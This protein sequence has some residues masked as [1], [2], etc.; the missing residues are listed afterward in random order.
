MNPLVEYPNPRQYS[1]EFI[2][3]FL[4]DIFIISSIIIIILLFTIY[5]T[6]KNKKNENNKTEPKEIS[7]SQTSSTLNKSTTWL[8]DYKIEKL[9]GQGA[10]S[11]V[12]LVTKGGKQYA[13]KVFQHEDPEL[14]ERFKREIEILKQIKHI[15][16]VSI[17]DFGED[18]NKPY[19]I[20]EYVD[21]KTLD[22]IYLDL[23]FLQRLDI[24][25]AVSNALNYLHSKGIIHRDIKPENILVD[26]E[27]KNIK[28]TDLGISRI[29]YWRPLTQDGQILGT[30][31]YMAPEL[32]E[33]VYTDPRIDIYSLGITMYEIFTGKLPFEGSP[34]EIVIKHL[35]E[36]PV[37][38][39]LINP[40]IPTQLEKIIMKAIEKNPEKRYKNI[41]KLI[42]DLILV[43]EILKKS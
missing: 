9:L 8:G 13:A 36:T 14:L 35:K 30:P 27:L 4:S 33:G 16:L 17:V 39:S 6:K 31:A 41:S 7:E 26:K 10:T 23:T 18:N 25:I 1:L 29:V 21:G 3:G 22:E 28:L 38:P 42:E 32:F 2:A 24:I 15:N 34:S 40:N 20:L 11:K 5:F 43:R 37:L 19:L 12:Y